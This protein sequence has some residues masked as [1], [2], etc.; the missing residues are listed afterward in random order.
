MMYSIRFKKT[1]SKLSRECLFRFEFLMFV[2]QSADE[3]FSPSQM[4]RHF[5]FGSL[6]LEKSH[7]PH[8]L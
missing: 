1:A 6:F 3:G 2:I 5:N 8:Y 4:L 7:A